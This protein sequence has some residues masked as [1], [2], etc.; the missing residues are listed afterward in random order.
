[1]SR[2]AERR[3]GTRAAAFG[4]TASAIVLAIASACSS[5]SAVGP[6]GECFL[7]TDCTPGL[8]CVEQENKARVCSDDLTRVAGETPEPRGDAGGGDGTSDA[9]IGDGPVIPRDTGT[10]PDTGGPQPDTG[11]PVDAGDAG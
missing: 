5:S 4:A 7:A 10:P 1:M 2:H 8:V 11:A 6:G 3:S 9:P